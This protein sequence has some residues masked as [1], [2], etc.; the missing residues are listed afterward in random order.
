MARIRQLSSYRL[1]PQQP[2]LRESSSVSQTCADARSCAVHAAQPVID[3]IRARFSSA[4]ASAPGRTAQPQPA[5]SSATGH[6]RAL[7][8]GGATAPRL[9]GAPS[10]APHAASAIGAATHGGFVVDSSGRVHKV[11]GA[12]IEAAPSQVSAVGPPQASNAE[13]SLTDQAAPPSA[14]GLVDAILR[15]AGQIPQ[16][17]YAPLSSTSDEEGGSESAGGTR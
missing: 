5:V 3:C 11:A 1:V 7:G 13:A 16:T 10:S 14:G 6:G 2:V 4:A 15:G 9:P 12:V 8:S 17:R